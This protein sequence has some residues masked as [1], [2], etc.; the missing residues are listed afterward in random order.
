MI[1]QF[2][3]KYVGLNVLALYFAFLML[4]IILN[5]NMEKTMCHISYYEH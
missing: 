3:V 4:P 1:V 5:Q 2:T